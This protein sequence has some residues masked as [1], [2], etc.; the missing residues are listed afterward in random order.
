VVLNPVPEVPPTLYILNVSLI[1]HL[2]QVISSLE[3]TPRSEMG[4]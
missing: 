2:I 1:K 3:K 4:M